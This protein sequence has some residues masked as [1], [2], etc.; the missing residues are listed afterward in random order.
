MSKKLS[1]TEIISL[2]KDMIKKIE[3]L[4]PQAMS[5]A[6]SQYDL[7]GLYYLLLSVV[8]NLVKKDRKE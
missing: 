1:K 5:I 6:A 8:D 3:D 2:I 7:L 4:P